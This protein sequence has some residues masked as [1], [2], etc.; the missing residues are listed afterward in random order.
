MFAFDKI[1]MSGKDNVTVGSK[2]EA[3]QATIMSRFGASPFMH[4]IC[5]LFYENR[6]SMSENKQKSVT[7]IH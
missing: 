6:P 4:N 7:G 5:Q 2:T 1:G 3:Q